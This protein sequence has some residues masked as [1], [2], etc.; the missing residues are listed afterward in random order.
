MRDHQKIRLHLNQLQ[1]PPVSQL[2]LLPLRPSRFPG[3]PQVAL[4]LAIV[5]LFPSPLPVGSAKLK[6]YFHLQAVVAVHERLAGQK[7]CLE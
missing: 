7:A 4:A 5:L 3:G 1:A 6:L 2:R